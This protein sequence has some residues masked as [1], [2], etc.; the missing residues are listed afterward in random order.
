VVIAVPP[1]HV[2]KVIGSRGATIQRLRH[3]MGVAI[4]LQKDLT[5]AATVTLR[6]TMEAMRAAKVAIERIIS[7]GV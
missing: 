4:D 2:G 1:S 5:G 6:G 7:E 3:E